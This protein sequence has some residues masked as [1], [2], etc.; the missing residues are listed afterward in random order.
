MYFSVILVDIMSH[1]LSLYRYDVIGGFLF[2]FFILL[3]T[4]LPAKSDND[5][6]FCL[7]SYQGLIIDRSLVY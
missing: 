4:V 6:K 2:L 3:G 5:V 7:Q 1:T